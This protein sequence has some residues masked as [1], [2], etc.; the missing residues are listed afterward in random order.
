MRKESMVRGLVAESKAPWVLEVLGG[1]DLGWEELV[2]EEDWCGAH[3]LLDGEEE[4]EEEEEEEKEEVCGRE[5]ARRE[6]QRSHV[7]PHGTV[8]ADGQGHTHAACSEKRLLDLIFARICPWKVGG[9]EGGAGQGREWKHGCIQVSHD[10]C[11]LMEC[12]CRH[13]SLQG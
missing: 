11:L 9:R 13:A 6:R 7:P 1:A 3:Q 12:P 8:T 4:E 10:L 5:E 2:K